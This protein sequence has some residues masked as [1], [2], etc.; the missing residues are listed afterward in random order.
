MHDTKIT[1]LTISLLIIFLFGCTNDSINKGDSET[2]IE[3][4]NHLN[5]E[6]GKTKT[7]K[8]SKSNNDDSSPI[9]KLLQGKWQH[10]EDKTNYLLFDGNYRKEI[11][12]SME[13]WN[14]EPFILSNK[15]LN[16]IDSPGKVGDDKYISCKESDLCWYIIELDK[17]GLSLSYVGRGNTLKY[18]R[19]N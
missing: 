5:T 8:I 19:V 17:E 18:K 10:V 7:N 13:S 2:L 16:E 3:E 11:A 12:G 1:L 15:C 9:F 4:L 14:N 6:Q